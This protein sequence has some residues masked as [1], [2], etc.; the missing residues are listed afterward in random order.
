[1]STGSTRVRAPAPSTRVYA[2]DVD[3]DQSTHVG[4]RRPWGGHERRLARHDQ[5]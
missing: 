1:M 5:P 3:D 4:T 2:L